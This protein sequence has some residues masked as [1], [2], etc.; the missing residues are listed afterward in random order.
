[1][2]HNGADCM[3]GVLVFQDVVQ[4]PEIQS[5]KKFNESS[6]LPGN[7]PITMHE[8]EVLCQVEDAEIPEGGWVSG[9]ALF[10]SV[11][12]SLSAEVMVRFNIF[13]MRYM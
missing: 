11:L 10:G 5:K 12:S 8:A 3:S 2:F 7:P 4:A 1:M 9:D 6:H 13:L